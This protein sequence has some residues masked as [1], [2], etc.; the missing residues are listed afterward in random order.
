VIYIRNTST[1]RGTDP[2]TFG[3]FLAVSSP[4]FFRDGEALPEKMKQALTV[5]TV[6]KP[7]SVGR[8]VPLL[9]T[10]YGLQ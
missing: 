1:S 10:L 3:R 4:M 8:F 5:F 7:F 9:S 6:V 2:V